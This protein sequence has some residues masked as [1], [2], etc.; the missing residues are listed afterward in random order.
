MSAK[1]REDMPW[2]ETEFD[3]EFK[4]WILNFSTDQLPIIYELLEKYRNDRNIIVFKSRDDSE[5]FL[6][7]LKTQTHC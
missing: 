2:V 5:R 3:D 1:K 6:D 7:T 4:R